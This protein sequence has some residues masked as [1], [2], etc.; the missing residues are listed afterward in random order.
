MLTEENFKK[1][2]A[3][4]KETINDKIQSVLTCLIIYSDLGKSPHTRKLA[5]SNWN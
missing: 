3:D 4:V 2:C 1:L 5:K